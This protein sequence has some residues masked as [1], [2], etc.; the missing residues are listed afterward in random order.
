MR[1]GSLRGVRLPS[2]PARSGRRRRRRR[3]F[4]RG[5]REHEARPTDLRDNRAARFSERLR[6]FWWCVSRK[7]TL[8]LLIEPDPS[9]DPLFQLQA[10][11]T[12][13]R[14]RGAPVVA[15]ELRSHD[16]RFATGVTPCFLD[17]ARGFSPA[18]PY[19][20]LTAA[21]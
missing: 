19:G 18:P 13:Q 11:T 12:C 20:R 1:N 3:R 16:W 21:N 9:N 4:S 14:Q 7:M 17:D 10:A 5:F 6:R 2:C 8:G 15:E